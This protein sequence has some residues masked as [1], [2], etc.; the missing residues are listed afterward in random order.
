MKDRWR[1]PRRTGIYRLVVVVL[2][3]LFIADGTLCAALCSRQVAQGNEAKAH[4]ESCHS[5]PGNESSP[6]QDHAKRDYCIS[7][8]MLYLSATSDGPIL[9]N[10]ADGHL[11]AVALTALAEPLERPVAELPRGPPVLLSCCRLS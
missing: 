10:A 11:T 9:V 5:G 8:I 7:C 1:L 4:A 3:A 2:A 6:H